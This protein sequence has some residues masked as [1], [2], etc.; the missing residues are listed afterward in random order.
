MKRTAFLFLLPFFAAPAFAAGRIECNTLE[1]RYIPGR[2]GYCALLP[3]SYDSQPARKFP[4]LYFLHGLGEDPSFLITSGGWR[5]VQDAQ[6]Q[7]RI[8]EFVLITPQAGGSFYI[9]SRDGRVKYEDFFIRDFIPQMEKRFRLLTTRA[10]RAVGGVSMGGYG[11][12]HL[13]FRHPQHFSAVSAHSAALIEKLP[14]FLST[15][16]SPRS[17][18]LGAVFGIPPD[19]AFWNAHSPLELARTANLSGLKIYFD[20]GDQDGY[21]FDV[22]ATA[23]DETLT[24]RKTPHEFHIYPGRHDPAYFAAHIPASLAFHSRSF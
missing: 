9:N 22:G 23:L 11:A 24:A 16:Q 15:P 20:C 1:S 21:G 4:V 10:G 7:K 13:A 2:I 18:V 14:V 3:P 12:L 19:T 6:E 8:R 17:R 5:L